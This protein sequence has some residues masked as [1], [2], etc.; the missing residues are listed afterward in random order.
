MDLSVHFFESDT[1]FLVFLSLLILTIIHR[2]H[3]MLMKRMWRNNRFVV[4]KLGF[5]EDLTL[6]YKQYF[7]G[8]R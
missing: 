1:F 8:T 2:I 6:T 7:I 4:R 5:Y 3:P